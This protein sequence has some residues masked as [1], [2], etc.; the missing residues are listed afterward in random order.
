[1]NRLVPAALCVL[2][3]AAY[4]LFYLITA[5]ESEGASALGLTNM[6]GLIAVFIGLIAAGILFR[7]ATPVR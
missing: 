5:S 6:V 2:V 4:A 7:R 1:L 3:V